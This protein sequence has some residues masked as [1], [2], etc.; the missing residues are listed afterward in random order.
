MTFTRL[1]KFVAAV[2]VVA[3]SGSGAWGPAGG[4]PSV[5]TVACGP[6]PRQPPDPAEEF[7]RRY[8]LAPGEDLKRIPPPFPE[9]RAAYYNGLFKGRGGVGVN[10]RADQIQVLFFQQ[11]DDDLGMPAATIGGGGRKGS[12]L[13][14]LLTYLLE[15]YPQDVEGKKELLEAFVEGDFV[16]RKGASNERLAERLGTIL[17]DE[18]K[19]TV[20]LGLREVDRDVVV[21]KGRYK[22]RPVE[23]KAGK[24]ESFDVYGMARPENSGAGGGSGS[25]AEMLQWVGRFTEPNSRIVNEA[26]D[27]P[28]GNVNWRLYERSPFTPRTRLED[29][30][31][32]LVFEHLAE[33]T[34]LTFEFQERKVKVL[35]VEPTDRTPPP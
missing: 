10:Y 21:A 5:P 24:D 33:Q 12:T 7:Q 3:V 4:A 17:R 18:C 15:I 16:A 23:G 9:S 35:F 27:L 32:A 31:K 13:V 29:H 14:S 8:R 2:A 25:F 19:L 34:G 22:Y 28:K 1:G 6:E 11:K 30:D 20:R 26:T